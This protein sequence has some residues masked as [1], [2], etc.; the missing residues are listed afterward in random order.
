MHDAGLRGLLT[1]L[2]LLALL[3]GCLIGTDRLAFRD[4]SHFYTPLYDYVGERCSDQ[5]LPL[6][7]PLDQT[8][9]SLPGETT[10]AVFYPVRYVLFCLPLASETALAWYV[11]LHLILA[12]YAAAT[13]ARWSG[14]RRGYQIVAGAVYPLSGGVFFLYTNPPFL[15]GAAWMPLALGALIATEAIRPRKRILIAAV[16]L[17]MTVMAGDPQTALHCVVIAAATI[18]VASLGSTE[19]RSR[20]LSGSGP[21]ILASSCLLASLLAAPQIA[22]SLD[23][24]RQSGRA[25]NADQLQWWQPPVINS[26]RDEAFHFSLAPWHLA[27]LV[28]PHASGQ[29]LPRNRRVTALLPGDGRTWTPTIYASA[30]GLIAIALELINRFRPQKPREVSRRVDENRSSSRWLWIGLGGALLSLGHFGVVWCVQNLTGRLMNVDSAIGGPYWF[31]YQFLPGYESFRYPAKWLPFVSLAVAVLSARWMR[32][33]RISARQP[34]AVKR[35]L[36]ICGAATLVLLITASMTG[37]LSHWASADRALPVDE[38]WGRLDIAAALSGIRMSLVHTAMAGAAIATIMVYAPRISRRRFQLLITLVVL[39]DAG[40]VANAILATVPRQVESAL[41]AELNSKSNAGQVDSDSTSRL[42]ENERWLR[43]QSD[44][45]WPLAWRTVQS[46]NR[47]NEVEA[48]QRTAWFG[49]WHLSERTSVFNNMTSIRPAAVDQFWKS[50]WRVTAD[51]TPAEKT[52]FW[53]NCKQWLAITGETQATGKSTIV[54]LAEEQYTVIDR[55][56]VGQPSPGHWRCHQ[57]W[58]IDSPAA[59]QMDQTL[60]GVAKAGSRSIPR[61]IMSPEQE[62]QLQIDLRDL[63]EGAGLAPQTSTDGTTGSLSLA[64]PNADRQP[65]QAFVG[66]RLPSMSLVTRRVYQD[67][68]WRAD[69]AVAGASSVDA[70][71]AAASDDDWTP[72]VVHPVDHLA[73]GVILPPGNWVVRFTYR[74][75]WLWPSLLTSLLATLCVLG[76]SCRETF[77]AKLGNR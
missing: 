67:G 5:W 27:E 63:M 68:N 54:S 22:A 43:T 24:S 36:K 30:I 23:W 13:A 21:A 2:A 73:Q 41:I 53:A 29:L 40:L 3:C 52:E 72:I 69:Y 65:E 9:I 75:S 77:V 64:K 31:L 34:N 51:M 76:A 45:G 35:L 10:T 48:S 18:A 17:A 57:E 38:Y 74:P 61:L 25:T 16:A 58:T 60:R 1:P 70:S 49:R 42:G 32:V 33:I 46:D 71:I 55:K 44:G 20:R 39:I 6:W 26:K 59:D 14:I 62:T 7:N 47:L 15:V 50:V 66:A 19:K 11:V 28:T 56:R 12:S 37:L 8:G 4:V